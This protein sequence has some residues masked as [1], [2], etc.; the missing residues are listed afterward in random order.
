[1]DALGWYLLKSAAW[2]TTFGLI[3]LLFLKN[4]RYFL[5]N[6]IYLL[7][8]LLAAVLFPLYDWHYQVEIPMVYFSASAETATASL[9]VKNAPITGT[10]ILFLVYWLIGIFFAIRLVFQT[11]K[12]WRVIR[13]SVFIHHRSVKVI[14]SEVYPVS[15]SFFT[16]VI[17][18]PSI[19]EAEAMEIIRHETEH[20]RQR[21]WIDLALFECNFL[22]QW[23]NPMMWLYGK[24][25][26][27]NH[28]Y[29]A[30]RKAL[31]NTQNPA[32]YRAALLNQ[33]FGG[34]VIALSNSFNYSLNTKRFNMMKNS[35]SSPLRK[36]KVL[37]I[38]PMMAMLFY[39]FATPEYV[40]LPVNLPDNNQ[41]SFINKVLDQDTLSR[42]KSDSVK[43][44]K[45]GSTGPANG[46]LQN[47]SVR[48]QGP[49][50]ISADARL[51]E[52]DGKN[53]SD[54]LKQ[55]NITVRGKG[56]QPL[57]I[58]DGMVKKHQTTKDIHPATIQSI[59]VWKGEQA[60]EK[61]GEQA[62]DGA[63]EITLKSGLPN[64]NNDKLNEI[65]VI[66][67]KSK[68]DTK[69]DT[70]SHLHTFLKI[71]GEASFVM[72]DSQDEVPSIREKVQIRGIN[73]KPLLVID[74]VVS[75][76][77][78]I[79]SVQPDDIESITILKDKSAALVYGEKGKAGV[80]LITRKKTGKEGSSSNPNLSLTLAKPQ[81]DGQA[82]KKNVTETV[83]KDQ[84]VENKPLIVRDGKIAEDQ[85]ITE[86]GI[87]EVI[88]KIS[89]LKGKEATDRY[90]DMGK[91]G[92]IEL[93]TKKEKGGLD[94]PK[95]DHKLKENN[96]NDLAERKLNIVADAVQKQA[97]VTIEGSSD[98]K[99][100]EVSLYDKFGQLIQKE[101]YKGPTFTYS[102]KGLATGTYFMVIEDGINRYTG[103]L[104]Y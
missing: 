41:N 21:H 14:S 67:Y 4:E 60:V 53:E 96:P 30:D 29:L 79:K 47:K 66:G 44:N 99:R 38:L 59:H 81:L 5:L 28:E 16:Y 15:F 101:R 65:S 33:M 12:V 55:A 51:F 40:Y 48:M 83:L 20:V 62:R 88:E 56:K 13:H 27:Q 82:E 64:I 18:N 17:V 52:S 78:N 35:Y 70:T 10:N 1:M 19:H 91:N 57:Y 74:G 2:L 49:V 69:S 86:F 73:G 71:N 50:I 104:K 87:K 11:L 103:F 3:Y 68:N 76:D 95:T 93:T 94:W 98:K 8:G 26:R 24:F 63:I 92:V 84:T 32:L 58:V 7:F 61:F 89:I 46:N 23:F 9:P 45:T 100:V 77:Q 43:E 72:E 90:G 85:N 39:A 54:T 75:V 31:Q 42:V 97:L 36:M 6:R 25:I 22:L 102:L 80:I 37:L 34:S